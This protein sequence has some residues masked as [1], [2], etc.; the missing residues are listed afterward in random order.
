MLRSEKDKITVQTVMPGAEIIT[1]AGEQIAVG[2]PEEVVKAWMRAGASP[3][4]W[5]IPDLR[6]S[7]G[8]VQWALE[9][10]LYF[11]LFVQGK[12][13]RQEKVRVVVHE[14]DWPQ[15][16]DYLRLTLLGLDPLELRQAGVEPEVAAMLFSEGQ[17]LALKREDGT[18]AGIED[19]CEPVFFD[20]EQ[21]VDLG[22]LRIRSHGDNTWSFYTAEDRIEEYRLSIEELQVP[23]YERPVQTADTPV[24]PQPF[25][26]M[27]LGTSSGFDVGGPCSSLLVQTNGRFLLI[28]CGPYV[29][30][31]LRAAGVSPNQIEAVIITHAHEDHAVGL[32]A[33]LATTHRLKLL[34]SRENLEILRRK[35]AIL[36][37]D[38]AKPDSLLADTF[39]IQAVTPGQEH[40]LM[41]LSLKFH[42]SMHAIPCT[43]VEL[44]MRDGGCV[45]RVLVVGDHNSRQ[46]IQAA[47]QTGVIGNR[48]LAELEALYEW[49]GDL[50]I[51][52]AGA[53]QIHGMPADFRDNQ[54]DTVVCVHTG[55]LADSERHLYSL[56]KPGHRWTVVP[57][58]NRPTPLERGLAHRA[59]VESFGIT[60]PD[61]LCAL[62]DAAIPLS[63]NRD[64]VVV[65]CQD[66]GR[67]LYVTL[68]GELQVVIESDGQTRCLANIQ[69]GEI[70][71]EMAAVSQAP[72][73]ASVIAV[74]PARLLRIPDEAFARFADRAKLPASLPAIWDKRTALDSAGVL[75]Q[76]SVTTKNRIARS[77]VRRTI[78]PGSTLI[79][80]GSHSSTVFVLVQGRV[81]VY[82]GTE[83]LMIDGQPVI[84]PEGSLLGETAPFLNQLRNASIV[85]VDE[86]EVLAIRGSDFK[87]IVTAS[88]QMF[89]RISH[90]VRK[91]QAA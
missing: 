68:T 30:T 4:A 34:A 25:E 62:L 83:P 70:F 72:R 77:A 73:S 40:E 7:D 41:G 14:R 45:R 78:A 1:A 22:G 56:A 51:A 57:E 53:G 64:Q 10:P 15:V 74:T 58:S 90:V 26:V 2:F 86:C 82:K 3:S 28:D 49:K 19:F 37:P 33:L 23:P 35:L 6:V 79:R 87:R 54:S 36:N 21:M 85:T 75:A 59:L 20:A 12:F 47:A 52:D 76:A 43:G 60:E 48:R 32:S 71:G 81:Q 39:D 89:F 13:A 63:V 65:R 27:A 11:G 44:S 18:V 16:V 42:Y 17:H 5:L 29:Q 50:L 80:E 91:R 9:F 38:V 67:D 46:N 31:L 24:L 55:S 66:P 88:P 69:A 84:V 8:I 61:A